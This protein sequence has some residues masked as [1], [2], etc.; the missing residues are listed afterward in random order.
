M[1]RFSIREIVLLT[2]IVA[3]ACGWTIERRRARRLQ[4]DLKSAQ[5]SLHESITE[6][7]R[8]HRVNEITASQWAKALGQLHS[9][10]E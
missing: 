9:P 5:A 1:L 10:R 3:L 2:L 4:S 6:M 8:L 7:R